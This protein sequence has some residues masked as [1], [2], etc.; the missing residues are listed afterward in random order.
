ID[1]E[2][3][4]GSSDERPNLFAWIGVPLIVLGLGAALIAIGLWLGELEGGGPLGIRPAA[5]EASPAVDAASV[6]VRPLSLTAI[7]PFGDGAELSSIAGL[8]P[9]RGPA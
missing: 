7:D 8:A 4:E 6:A 5:P 9:P 3:A 1:A 2:H